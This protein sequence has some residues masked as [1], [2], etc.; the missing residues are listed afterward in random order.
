MTAFR[1]SNLIVLLV[2]VV[3][4]AIAATLL[5]RTVTL[6]Q[7]INDKAGNIANT[8]RGINV[9]TDSVIQLNRTNKTAGSIL[10]TATPLEGQ[11]NAIISNA[12]DIDRLAISINGTAGS[13]NGTATR[14]NNTAC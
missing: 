14:I 8:G 2:V 5:A 1:L 13:I 6:A 10:R 9:A 7:H 4:A 3:A 12:R 11:L